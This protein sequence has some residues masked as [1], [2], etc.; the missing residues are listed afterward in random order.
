VQL[1]AGP[2][3][4]SV[5]P[6]VVEK[7]QSIEIGTV[8]PGLP[9]DTLS[10]TQIGSTAGGTVSLQLVNGIEEV[11]YTAPAS[12][13]TSSTDALSYQ[14]TDQHNDA[15]ATGSASVQL[16]AGPAITSATPSAVEKGQTTIIGTVAPGLPGDTLSLTQTGSTVGGTVS[17]Q[18]LVDGSYQVIYS[19]PVGISVSGT[20]TVSYSVSDQHN[21]AVATGSA[22]VQLDAG[23]TLVAVAA[24]SVGGRQSTEIGTVAPGLPGDTLSLTQTGSS[25]GGTVNLQLVNGTYQVIYTA[26]ASL[27]SSPNVVTYSITDQHHV[28]VA[29][30]TAIVGGN[31]SQSVTANGNTTVILGNGNDTVTLGGTSNAVW[32][33]NGNDTVTVS[34]GGN[35]I[36]LGTG[37]DT[38]H[39]GT[40]DTILL[41]GKSA[42]L[43]ISGTSEMVFLGGGNDTVTDLGQ[44]LVLKL[45]PTS[46]K[47]VLANFGADLTHGVIDLLGGI[48]GFTSASQAYAALKSDGHGGSLLQLGHAMSLDITGVAP[49]QLHATNFMIG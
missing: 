45:G 46:G 17:L 33:G 24:S 32:L 36:S 43:G 26:P 5:T 27:G 37:H 47:D 7:G 13:A 20:D 40:G 18:Q 29:N 44:G 12:I 8:A 6:S 25:A 22:S 39:G 10:L 1:D 42:N 4:T 3:V 49:T 34:G 28:A 9:G 21:D 38:V 19:A 35:T 14:I 23:P 41:T 48:G 31:V 30:G 16:D 11:I 2:A 15:I